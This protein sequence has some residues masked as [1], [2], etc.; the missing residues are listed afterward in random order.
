[1]ALAPHRKQIIEKEIL[2]KTKIWDGWL[3]K[4]NFPLK[5]FEIFF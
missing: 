3:P 4:K 2:P 1:M 5:K